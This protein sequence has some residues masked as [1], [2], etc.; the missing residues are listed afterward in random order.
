VAPSSVDGGQSRQHGMAALDTGWR[1]GCTAGWGE[2]S[3]ESKIQPMPRKFTPELENSPHRV[4]GYY[5]K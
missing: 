4:V 5:S 3:L 1:A 2:F